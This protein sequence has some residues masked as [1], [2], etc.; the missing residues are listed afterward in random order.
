MTAARSILA[1][2]Q[3]RLT[4]AKLRGVYRPDEYERRKSAFFDMLL[5]RGAP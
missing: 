2:E 3:A 4:V 5:A 1:V